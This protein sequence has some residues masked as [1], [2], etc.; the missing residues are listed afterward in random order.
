MRSSVDCKTRTATMVLRPC[1]TVL[2]ALGLLTKRVATAPSPVPRGDPS[3]SI[4]PAP[5]PSA[6]LN[7]TEFPWGGCESFGVTSTDPNFQCGYLEVPMDY[8]D[9]SAGNARLAVIKY[10]ATAKKLGS[11]FFNPGNCLPPTHDLSLT[12]HCYRWTRG[13]RNRNHPNIWAEL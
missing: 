7:I 13:L 9:S 10:A 5:H 2:I 3:V 6:L 4:L 8:H 1:L 11:I 12:L